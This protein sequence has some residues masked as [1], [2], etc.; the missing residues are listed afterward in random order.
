M[1]LIHRLLEGVVALVLVGIMV[2]AWD[3]W[4]RFVWVDL[5]QGAAVLEP[6]TPEAPQV[7]E[8]GAYL[9][10]IGGCVA[11]HTRDGGPLMAG[12]RV[13]DTPFGRVFSS[14]LTASKTQGIGSWT[15]QLFWEALR[16]GRT[17]TGRLLIPAFPYNHT[18]VLTRQDSDAL[19]AW[20]QTVPAVDQA[21]I[22]AELPWPLGTQPMLAVWRTLF[23]KSTS[24]QANPQHSEEWNR[25]AYLVQG[26]L[27][28]AACHS[29]RNVL[30]GFNAVDDVSGGR[31][32][33]SRWIAPDLTQ[34]DQTLLGRSPVDEAVHWLRTG[35][36]PQAGAT[37]PMAIYIR[38]VAQYLTPED[39]RAVITYLQTNM[40]ATQ[41]S[42]APVVVLNAQSHDWLQAGAKIYANQC[43][44]CHGEQGQGRVGQYPALAHNAAVN[45]EQAD[46]VIQMTLFGGFVPSTQDNPR[47]WGMPPF[48]FTLHNDEIAQ[49][50]SYVRASWGNQ[51]SV[52]TAVEVDKLRGLA[53]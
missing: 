17:P 24:W 4:I 3:N 25:G 19:W 37:G 21:S 48:I 7:V 38:E 14:N 46:N 1:K 22:P 45:Q 11:C 40:V 51:G 35:F 13:I 50:L 10:R 2:V 33:P 36:S 30:G 5:T 12:A 16:W 29:Q 8:R 31:L 26:P 53:R 27:H 42:T 41:S 52:I 49:A 6:H 47:P 32:Q 23:F 34:V 44:G 43:A 18:S 15:P 9:A 28:C 20:L 39:A